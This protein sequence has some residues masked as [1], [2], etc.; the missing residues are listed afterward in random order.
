MNHNYVIIQIMN[1]NFY[2]EKYLLPMAGHT[3]ILKTTLNTFIIKLYI[4]INVLIQLFINFI[5][6][7]L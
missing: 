7:T 1:K 2:F 6:L 4:P 5:N 3:C